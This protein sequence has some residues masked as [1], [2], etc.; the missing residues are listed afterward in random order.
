MIPI[1]FWSSPPSLVSSFVH[2][3]VAWCSMAGLV[4]G[5]SYVIATTCQT[6]ACRAFC[7]WACSLLLAWDWLQA[8][9]V[10]RLPPISGFFLLGSW[11]LFQIVHAIS[12][13]MRSFVLRWSLLLLAI[14]DDGVKVLKLLLFSLSFSFNESKASVSAQLVWATLFVVFIYL[15]FCHLAWCLSN[16][17]S[18]VAFWLQ[19]IFSERRVVRTGWQVL[20]L[21]DF[22]KLYAEL[23]GVVSEQ[24]FFSFP[25]MKMDVRTLWILPKVLVALSSCPETKARK[26]ILQVVWVSITT[27]SKPEVC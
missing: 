13:A 24:W 12:K 10:A 2:V 7:C 9:L 22:M 1:C 19:L 6:V 25:E 11:H 4:A 23:V 15:L 21:N 27:S 26:F 20:V 16:L 5:S 17:R 14:V 3:V 8:I 18:V